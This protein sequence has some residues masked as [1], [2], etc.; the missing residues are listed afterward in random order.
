M[1]MRNSTASLRRQVELDR[2]QSKNEYLKTAA[3]FRLERRFNQNIYY[4]L[5]QKRGSGK[6][7][8]VKYGINEA[9]ISKWRKKLGIEVANP[10]SFKPVIL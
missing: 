10:T 5:D 3:M 9:T 4:L 1:G 8:A 2:G 6:T 7:L